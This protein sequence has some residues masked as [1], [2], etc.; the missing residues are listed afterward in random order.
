MIHRNGGGAVRLTARPVAA[1]VAAGL[2]A[3]PMIGTAGKA[4]LQSEWRSQPI[5]IDGV[6]NEWPALTSLGKDTRFS[7]AVRNDNENLYVV[8]MTSDTATALQ[9]VNEGLIVWFD[10]EGG[11]KKRFGLKYPLGREDHGSGDA[12]PKGG[13]PG[14][15][16]GAPPEGEG[17]PGGP[18]AAPQDPESLWRQALVEGRMRQ[19][20]V[21]GPD[22]DDHRLLMLDLRQS[23]RAKIGRADGIMVYE[24]CVPLARTPDV[25]EGLGVKPG[26]V[27][28]IGVER[29]ERDLAKE[30]EKEKEKERESGKGSFS[31]SSGQQPGMGGGQ[32]GMRGAG[33]MGG[34]GGG[35]GTWQARPLKV[36]NTVQLATEP[37]A[38]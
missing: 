30:R 27:I 20:E 12:Q 9:A 2:L 26:A 19:A 36:W 15:R 14:D 11:S 32:G 10:S 37:A 18:E 25:P 3:V 7:I 6:N 5:V 28:S 23:I 4:R 17:G 33:R 31:G 29:P 21:L 38:R 8:L 24:L 35:F 16:A 34:P 13:R 1:L 22:K